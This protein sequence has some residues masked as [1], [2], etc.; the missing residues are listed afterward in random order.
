MNNQEITK[1]DVMKENQFL[2]IKLS[3]V[4]QALVNQQEYTMDLE[5]EL[6]IA[7]DALRALNE[8][9]QEQAQG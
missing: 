4:L 1:E 5:T 9:E 6:H 3:K 2:K 8:T 7:H